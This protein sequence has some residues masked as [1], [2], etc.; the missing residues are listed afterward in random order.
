MWTNGSERD[1]VLRKSLETADD[2]GDVR[3]PITITH[4]EGSSSVRR[5]RKNNGTL[6]QRIASV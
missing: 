5:S 6:R 4:F 2:E 3:R 1:V